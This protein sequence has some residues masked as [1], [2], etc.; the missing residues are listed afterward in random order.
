MQGDQALEDAGDL[1]KRTGAHAVGVFL[2]AVLPV[3]VASVF[4]D[5]ESV[6]NLLNFA[7]ANHAA[8]SYAA[9]VLTGHHYLEAAGFDMEKVE[10]LNRGTDG[11]AADLFN[12]PHPMIGIDNL[13]AEMEIYV[14]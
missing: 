11:A 13:V 6:Q 8:Q 10:L 4:A 1:Q 3:A 2:E 12:N 5:R 14:R 9:G 7:V